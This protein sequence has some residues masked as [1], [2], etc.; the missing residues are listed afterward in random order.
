MILIHVTNTS[1][2]PRTLKPRLVVDT[3]LPFQFSP[4]DRQALVNHH[5]SVR[6][7]LAM[8]GI[9]AERGRAAPF[10]LMRSRCR[11]ARPPRSLSSTAADKARGPRR[12]R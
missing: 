11:P 5:E 12:C 2:E 3:M 8:T 10:N 9:H 6:A 4:G 7:S 1:A